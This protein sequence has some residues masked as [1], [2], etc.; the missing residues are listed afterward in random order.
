MN[1]QQELF[2]YVQNFITENN[3][4]C[5]ESIYQRDSIS[6][7]LSEFCE[8]CCEFVGYS[9]LE[10]FKERVTK[11]QSE[12]A[13]LSSPTQIES[14][15]EFKQ[16]VELVKEHP[17][18]IIRFIKVN[19]RE[20]TTYW[21]QLLFKALGA[22]PIIPEKDQGEVTKLADHWIKWLNVGEHAVLYFLRKERT[23]L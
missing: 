9:R 8:K 4:T 2:N 6:L 1:K 20:G 5:A 23:N 22:G 16:L 11:W 13:H 12:T 15:P 18:E 3:I 21:I 19:F 17:V 14:H 10:E 7:T